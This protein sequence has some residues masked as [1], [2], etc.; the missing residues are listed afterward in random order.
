MELA[1]YSGETMKTRSR[2]QSDAT[3]SKSFPNSKFNGLP[4]PHSRRARR[5]SCPAFNG[6]GDTRKIMQLLGPTEPKLSFQ[7]SF[8]TLV[9]WKNNRRST[10]RRRAVKDNKQCHSRRRTNTVCS[11]SKVQVE[12]ADESDSTD[13][14]VKHKGSQN[15]LFK[16]LC[17]STGSTQVATEK[18]VCSRC[19]RSKS[20]PP[21]RQHYTPRPEIYTLDK[22][23]P[24]RQPAPRSDT[25]SDPAS[26]N[27]SDK[28]FE[29]RVMR[30]FSS[31]SAPKERLPRLRSNTVHEPNSPQYSSSKQSP[32][33]RKGSHFDSPPILSSEPGGDSGADAFVLPQAASHANLRNP[34]LGSMNRMVASRSTADSPMSRVLTHHRTC[35]PG[36]SQQPKSRSGSNPQE[37]NE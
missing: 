8:D 12:M 3:A 21:A 18:E 31:A 20:D 11:Q 27:G 37:S 19:N 16:L 14:Q 1:T 36:S 28:G 30:G 24:S 22:K 29:G 5:G 7:R 9:P 33:E 32:F 34:G 4:K 10:I 26:M 17:C 15:V 23:C 6:K 35:S 2:A 13:R 25:Y